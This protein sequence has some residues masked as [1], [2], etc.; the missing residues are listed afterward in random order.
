MKNELV[1]VDFHGASL[2]AV[3]GN[4]P[5]E[6]L[7]AMKPVA[8]GMGVS[9]QGQHEKLSKHPV[10]STC[11][12]VILMQMPGDDQ[13]R[14][15]VFLSL[16]RLSFWLATIQPNK[17]ANIE[18]RAKVIAY[19]EECADVLFAHFFSKAV[20]SE[21][22]EAS[23][24]LVRRMDGILR[25]LSHKAAVAERQM[26]A[27][28]VQL[29]EQNQRIDDMVIKTNGRYAVVGMLK[30]QDLLIEFGAMEKGRKALNTRIGNALRN[31]ATKG[32]I[33]G[34]KQDAHDNKWM[35]PAEE[36]REFMRATGKLWIAE[37]NAAHKAKASGQGVLEFPASKKKQKQ[38]DLQSV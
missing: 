4:T 12:K 21:H 18:T 22:I 3:R 26:E 27:M 8:E 11:I 23:A 24:E 25:M 1:T 38:P 31:A 14:E 28:A 33:K 5:A 9:W 17:I 32:V 16:P 10:L 35:F 29:A 36:A 20:N 6:T 15:H 30:V 13:R 34:A 2:I 7:V 19:Q 37:H